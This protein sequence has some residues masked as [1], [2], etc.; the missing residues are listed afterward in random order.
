MLGGVLL[1]CLMSISTVVAQDSLQ[2]DTRVKQ[3][4]LLNQFESDYVLTANER[5]AL[6]QARLAYQYRIRKILDSIDISEG[7]RRRLLQELKRNPLSEKVQAV[8]ANHIAPDKII[9]Q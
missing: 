7:K 2:S 5:V 4:M 1:C 6:K 8:I 3:R 9:E